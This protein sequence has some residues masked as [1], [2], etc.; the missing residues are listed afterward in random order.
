MPWYAPAD[1][2]YATQLCRSFSSTAVDLIHDLSICMSKRFRQVASSLH[3]A[4]AYTLHIPYET[5]TPL[6]LLHIFCNAP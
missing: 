4:L 6:Y 2:I 1:D 5:Y 3:I